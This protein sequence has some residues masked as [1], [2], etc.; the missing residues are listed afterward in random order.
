L[1]GND[2]T[3]V[4]IP[5]T[6]PVN[7]L[8]FVFS[9]RVALAAPVSSQNKYTPLHIAAAGGNAEVAKALLAAGANVDATDAVSEEGRGERLDYRDGAPYMRG[10]V[11]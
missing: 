5:R 1:Q 7:L 9:L 10:G 11:T 4:F 2:V 6:T 3:C 8:S